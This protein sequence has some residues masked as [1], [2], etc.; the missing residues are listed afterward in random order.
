[1]QLLN[2]GSG[3]SIAAGGSM[4]G[5]AGAGPPGTLTPST[6]LDAI[7]LM[8]AGLTL[9]AHNH[10]LDRST[11]S[12]SVDFDRGPP[13]LL[14]LEEIAAQIKVPYEIVL[15]AAR[16]MNPWGTYVPIKDPVPPTA[17]VV[18]REPTWLSVD[19]LGKLLLS[20]S[21]TNTGALATKTLPP[22][23]FVGGPAAAAAAMTVAAA[24]GGII[25]ANKFV[26]LQDTQ[27]R[28]EEERRRLRCR[29]E[30]R[31]L[32]ALTTWQGMDLDAQDRILRWLDELDVALPFRETAFSIIVQRWRQGGRAEYASDDTDAPGYGRGNSDIDPADALPPPY[33]YASGEDLLFVPF[34]LPKVP[35][36]SSG[37]CWLPWT[38][39]SREVTRVIRLNGVPAGFH[40]VLLANLCRAVA[41]VDYWKCWR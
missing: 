13:P 18:A 17:D 30:H 22:T 38:P 10:P 5:M 7:S 4:S 9:P 11:P 1:M 40:G 15:R 29:L 14:P 28:F 12:A 32:L 20:V 2:A 37:F 6:S 31:R 3:A 16:L 33:L 27:W 19:L 39:F 35:T 24:S 25:A 26:D 36:R 34:A 8:A 23:P 21:H 41:A